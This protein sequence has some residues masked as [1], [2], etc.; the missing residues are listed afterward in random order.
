L[1]GNTVGGALRRRDGG[2]FGENHASPERNADAR[3][4]SARPLLRSDKRG[5]NSHHTGQRPSG[6]HYD[7]D[8]AW[9]VKDDTQRPDLRRQ[10]SAA[11][12]PSMT[13]GG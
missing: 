1:T 8:T 12:R 7:P 5:I 11:A 9:C 4:G 10:I 3:L 6:W 13:P 2:K